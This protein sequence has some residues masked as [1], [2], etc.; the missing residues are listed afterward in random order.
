MKLP[1]GRFRWSCYLD[2]SCHISRPLSPS[3]R[4]CGPL[5]PPSLNS[6]IPARL[7][8]VK[9]YI[10]VSQNSWRFAMA[11]GHMIGSTFFAAPAG[12]RSAFDT[13]RFES[14]AANLQAGQFKQVRRPPQKLSKLHRLP[15]TDCAFA[16]C[17]RSPSIFSAPM[18][19]MEKASCLE[20]TGSTLYYSPHLKFPS[21]NKTY[22]LRKKVA[23]NLCAAATILF[24][25]CLY[26][27]YGL[28]HRRTISVLSL[29]QCLRLK[30]NAKDRN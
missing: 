19:Y 30:M 22:L 28:T 21:S 13:E 27:F 15:S 3:P 25:G 14:S 20:T 10:N 11:R 6:L 17:M 12:W 18:H 4:G 1:L 24:C 16:N 23:Q 29:N 26:G 2:R 5:K 8:L 9:S 7:T